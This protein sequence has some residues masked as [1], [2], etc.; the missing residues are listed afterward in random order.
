LILA[1]ELFDCVCA[2]ANPDV[3]DTETVTIAKR[4]IEKVSA[5]LSFD[6]E[7]FD[8]L[9]SKLIKGNRIIMY[10]KSVYIFQT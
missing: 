9:F 3:N 6:I 4:A 5:I 10:L 7:N 1:V 8:C 2:F